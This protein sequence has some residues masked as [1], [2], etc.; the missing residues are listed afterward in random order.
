M[1]QSLRVLGVPSSGY[2]AFMPVPVTNA[3]AATNGN[4]KVRALMGN[5]P[6][7]SPRPAATERASEGY[8]HLTDSD[9]SPDYI[10]PVKYVAVMNEGL[11]AP[12]RR[13][14]HTPMPAPALT[15]N[16]VVTG[17]SLRVPLGGNRVTRAIR[18]FISWPTYGGR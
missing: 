15:V 17:T 13:F 12:V 10:L 14:G 11:M 8:P 16:Q 4:N 9:N 6:V 7:A 5:V 2:S 3:A 1:R 18:P